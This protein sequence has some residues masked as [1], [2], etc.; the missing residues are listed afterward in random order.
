MKHQ[1]ILFLINSAPNYYNFFVALAKCFS[2]DGALVTIATDSNYSRK[3]CKLDSLNYEIY[4]FEDFFCAHK[5]DHEILLRYSEFDLNGALL[6]DFERADV[7]DIWGDSVNIE[8][9]DRIKSALLSFYEQ[10]FARNN[11]NVVVHEN[12]S[13]ALSHFAFFVTQKWKVI[14]CGIGGSRLPGRF[15]VTADPMNDDAAASLFREIQ[16][17]KLIVTGELRQWAADYITNIETVVPDYMKVNG[18]D[19]IGL[20]ERYLRC[21]QL[22]KL[23]SL[24]LHVFDSR[25]NA[26]QI[27]NPLRT[28][29][30]LFLRNVRR[31]FKVGRVM[32]MYEKPMEGE[33]FLIY[34]MHFH[35]ESSTSILAG[36]YLDEYEVIR[37]IAFNLPEGFRLYVKD[38][39]SAWG[40]PSLDFYRRIKRLPNVRLLGPNEPT[41]QLIKASVGVI[42]LTSTV[43]YEALLLKTRVFLFGQVFYAFHKGV[44]RIENPTKLRE[45]IQAAIAKLVDWDDAYNNDF[46]CAYHQS[47]LPGTLNLMLKDQNATAAARRVYEEVIRGGAIG[48]LGSAYR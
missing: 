35:P 42:T 39:I 19:R 38:H 12:V 8:Y 21:D 37:N 34:P 10:I 1:K 29:V 25:T 3:N 36:T 6:S 46:V 5:T 47:T 11:I 20:L 28:H 23:Q 7:Y 33:Q 24:L 15:S 4:N 22:A 26:F 18:L 32:R 2:G 48:S 43:G 30:N 13:S 27:G 41:K 17:G 45:V 31:R 14:Y 40:Y 9:Y 44:V 16:D